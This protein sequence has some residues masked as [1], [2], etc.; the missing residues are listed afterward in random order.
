MVSPTLP[1]IFPPPFIPLQAW[2]EDNLYQNNPWHMCLEACLLGEPRFRHNDNCTSN[3]SIA[4]GLEPHLRSVES[5]TVFPRWI[6]QASGMHAKAWEMLVH[7]ICSLC[8]KYHW[9]FQCLFLFRDIISLGENILSLKN[10]K[11]AFFLFTAM[12]FLYQRDNSSRW[13]P[14][15]ILSKLWTKFHS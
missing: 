3:V 4:R 12:L 7:I 11:W 9:K 5:N 6:L 13:D 14:K 15:I 1:S 2:S 8:G 10:G